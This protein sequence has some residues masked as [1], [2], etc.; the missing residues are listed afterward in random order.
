MLNDTT[1]ALIGAGNM[2]EAL[3]GGILKAGL[4]RPD[5]I[6]ATDVSAERLRWFQAQFHVRVNTNNVEATR[7]ADVVILCIKPQVMD[8][9]LEEIKRFLSEKRLIISVAAGV[10]L[11]RIRTRVGTVPL[12]RAMPNTPA[13]VQEGATA[14]APGAEVPESLLAWACRIFESLGKVVITEERLMDAVTGLSGSG[15]AYV[16]M[17]IE[18]LTDGG[19]LM[20]LPRSV[21]HVLAAQT[22][23]G[24]ARMVVET[25]DHPAVL[26]DRVTSPGGTTIA[27]VHALESGALRATIMNAVRA[28]TERAKELGG[29]S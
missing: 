27:G 9:V 26:K 25:G 4:V 20:G 24:A 16:Y 18:A 3:V 6:V 14:L 19:V 23:L 5:D 29:T 15:P 17:M 10:P 13:I 1:I 21:A 28:A 12:I 8:E 11:A 22:V 7:W 2:A